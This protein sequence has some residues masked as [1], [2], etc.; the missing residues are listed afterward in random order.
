MTYCLY[1]DLRA[2]R[3]ANPSY[4]VVG[5]HIV[6]VMH[7]YTSCLWARTRQSHLQG[8]VC[9]AQGYEKEPTLKPRQ[10]GC[11]L[12]GLPARCLTS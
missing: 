10:T 12:C 2:I 5:I 4:Q 9:R 7:T 8:V 11:S 6:T 1:P 3:T